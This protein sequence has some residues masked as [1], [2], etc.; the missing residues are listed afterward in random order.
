MT[1][2]TMEVLPSPACLAPVLALVF[3]FLGGFGGMTRNPRGGEQDSVAGHPTE[4]ACF[5]LT[6]VEPIH[7]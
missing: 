3:S 2:Q 4:T 7:V 1:F 5:C 6:F